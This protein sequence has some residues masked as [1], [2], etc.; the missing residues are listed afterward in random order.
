MAKRS[1]NILVPVGIVLA[2]AGLA[3]GAYGYYLYSNLQGNLVN[4]VVKFAA[5]RTEAETNA[6]LAM[7]GGGAGFLVGALLAL[8]GA[9]RR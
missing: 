9:R 4:A 1:V 2:V 8:A 7:I 5:G 6:V 3:V